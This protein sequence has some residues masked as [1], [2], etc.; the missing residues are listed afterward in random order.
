MEAKKEEEK[1]SDNI[2]S[3]EKNEFFQE[4]EVNKSENKTPSKN[5]Y[6]SNSEVY[7]A[8][9][10]KTQ[11]KYNTASNFNSDIKKSTG[12]LSPK[13]NMYK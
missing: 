6:L 1:L 12:P 10:N 9:D 2:V 3:N 11:I 4:K 8:K 13:N 5:G 7:S